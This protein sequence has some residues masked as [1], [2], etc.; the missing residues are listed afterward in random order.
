[1]DG[2]QPHTS[3]K[4]YHRSQGLKHAEGRKCDK[5]IWGVGEGCNRGVYYV[6]IQHFAEYQLLSTVLSL[7]GSLGLGGSRSWKI[8]GR[9]YWRGIAVVRHR[10]ES[11]AIAFLLDNVWQDEAK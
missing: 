10:W 4:G 2:L 1:M 8:F 3:L 6:I 7:K 5:G 9:S 11:T